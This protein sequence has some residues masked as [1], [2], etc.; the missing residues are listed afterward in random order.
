MQSNSDYQF[1][2]V[3][4][5]ITYITNRQNVYDSLMAAMHD[6]YNIKLIAA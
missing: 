3:I 5:C 6:D 4:K 2:L 1:G